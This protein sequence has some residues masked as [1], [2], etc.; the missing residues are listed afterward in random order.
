MKNSVA[1]LVLALVLAA[2]CSKS[3]TPAMTKPT[4]TPSPSGSPTDV[5]YL[6]SSSSGTCNDIKVYA[7]PALTSLGSFDVTGYCA[8]AFSA[9]ADGNLYAMETNGTSAGAVYE[10]SI[11]SST[12]SQSQSALCFPTVPG[13]GFIDFDDSSTTFYIAACTAKSFDLVDQYKLSDKT[14]VRTLNE[15]N[16]NTGGLVTWPRISVDAKG[17]PWIGFN[18]NDGTLSGI[19]PA[20]AYVTAQFPKNTSSGSPSFKVSG[21]APTADIVNDSTGAVWVLYQFLPS[22]D[23]T[24]TPYYFKPGLCTFDS[25]SPVGGDDVRYLLAQQFVNTKLTEE[26]FGSANPDSSGG[27]HDESTVEM[28]VDATGIDYVSYDYGTS[29]SAGVLVYDLAAGP[30]GPDGVPVRCPDAAHTIVQSQPGVSSLGIDS[31]NNLYVSN[32][33][34]GTVTQYAPGGQTQT[35][36]IT[37]YE[38]FFPNAEGFGQIVVRT[39]HLSA[40]ASSA[41]ERSAARRQ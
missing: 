7:L 36:Q 21:Q 11:G 22:Y 34:A 35:G 32:Q 10:F 14:P 27:L 26:L 23:I 4:P 8:G 17:N 41:A 25:S 18:A 39:V 29:S 2:G 24:P 3:S 1:V 5:L 37:G 38:P 6:S 40:S 30:N 31:A 16:N 28:A 9:D 33:T 20:H 12:S 13:N 19:K 15:P